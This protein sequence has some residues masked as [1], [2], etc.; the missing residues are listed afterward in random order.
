MWGLMQT[1]KDQRKFHEDHDI[2]I[3][4]S[5]KDGLLEVRNN[6]TNFCPEPSIYELL[7]TLLQPLSQ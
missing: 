2:C 7:Y 1:C 3:S 6:P 5:R 4:S